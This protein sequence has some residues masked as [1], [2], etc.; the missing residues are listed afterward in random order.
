MKKLFGRIRDQYH[1]DKFCAQMTTP[2]VPERM[3]RQVQEGREVRLWEAKDKV[4]PSWT[5][6]AQGIGDCVSWGA[7]LGCTCILWNLAAKGEIDFPG[8]V[9]TEGIYGG[10]RVEALGESSGGWSDGAAGSWAA[11]W[12]VK[13][14]VTLRVDYSKE[15]GNPEHDMRKYSA[16]K[17]KQWGYY[18]NGGQDDKEAFDKIARQHPAADATLVRNFKEAVAVISAGCTVTV[19]SGIG[20]EGDRDQDGIVRIRG[21]WPHQMVFLG[22]GWLDDGT[23]YLYQFNSWG[24]DSWGGPYPGIT[25]RAVMG[26]SC[27]V[28]QDDADRQLG[29]GDSYALSPIKGFTQQL[30][31]FD[32]GLHV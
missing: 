9:N 28:H 1:R 11:E 16:D 2:H 12:L 24:P 15:T 6:D 22:C 14:G 10:C 31:D 25:D 27:R 23:G 26:C 18:G 20:Y 13:Y 21:G 4:D 32:T 8:R 29:E 17:A 5:R 30:Y 3:V 19:A 7:E